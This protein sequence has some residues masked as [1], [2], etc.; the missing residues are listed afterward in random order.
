MSQDLTYCYLHMT[1]HDIEV[2]DTIGTP[3]YLNG[4]LSV[5]GTQCCYHVTFTTLAIF[6]RGR[7]GAAQA[8]VVGDGLQWW[9][10]GHPLPE[11][12]SCQAPADVMDELS[13]FD[14][15]VDSGLVSRVS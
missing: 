2:L 7:C 10:S 12:A 1:R 4:D 8:E 14:S 15:V 11:P 13:F 9:G 6:G 3:D 5:D